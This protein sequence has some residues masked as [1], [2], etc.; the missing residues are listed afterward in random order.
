MP[1][2]SAAP[3]VLNG[4]DVVVIGAS[5]GGLEP[6][7]R[8]VARLPPGWP[9]IVCVVWHI[10]AWRASSLPE[11]LSRSGPLPA[12]TPTHSEPLAHGHIYVAPPDHH[13]LFEDQT[14]YVWRGPRENL[15]RPSINVLFRSAAVIYRTR[16]IGVVLSGSGDDGAT[17]LWWIKRYGGIPIV[18]DPADAQVPAMPT[19]AIT[20]VRPDYILP[21]DTIPE[22]L[23]RLV[24]TPSTV[25]PER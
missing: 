17:G 2:E 23:I 7:K 1:G 10:P 9:A 3:L 12:S 25:V 24:A 20:T 21:A 18:Q 13:L 22:F 14:A 8:I 16:V 15:L 11:I 19:S 6:L 5:A 4:H